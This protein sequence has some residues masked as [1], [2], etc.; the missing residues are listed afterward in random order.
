MTYLNP[1]HLIGQD[2][3][4]NASIDKTMLRRLK[5]RMLSEF[6]LL[7][8]TT[9]SIAEK[10]M[11][12]DAV[13]KFFDRL[14]REDALKYHF[15]IYNNKPLLD[16]LEKGD[17]TFFKLPNSFE[18]LVENKPLFQFILPYFLPHFNEILHTA[19]RKMD[20][21]MINL[22]SKNAQ[23]IPKQKEGIA[24]LR[25]YH[26]LRA[27]VADLGAIGKKL[28][29]AHVFDSE[30]IDFLHPTF[31]ANF[32]ILPSPYFDRIRDEYALKLE[33]VALNLHNKARRTSLAIEALEAGLEL[34]LSENA[35]HRLNHILKQLL[36]KVS[37]K[38]SFG[39]RKE[40]TSQS[41]KI[42]MDTKKIIYWTLRLLFLLRLFFKRL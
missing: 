38:Q 18:K 14:E 27:R 4:A 35:A 39:K 25:T 37:Q 16:F 17:P 30:I 42:P 11:D 12:K 33:T 26:Y 24:Y 36:P 3:D 6:E 5:K 31:L 1:F 15:E 32:N 9:I 21:R 28:E 22:L 19:V 20:T 7:G 40:R 10:E 8:E 34:T 41:K 2:L 29:R 13:L 23:H